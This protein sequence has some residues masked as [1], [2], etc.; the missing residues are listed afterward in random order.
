M[1]TP[2]G[3]TIGL[4]KTDAPLQAGIEAQIAI[5]TAAAAGAV[6]EPEDDWDPSSTETA[7][8]ARPGFDQRW[9]RT[10]IMAVDDIDNLAKKRN[11]R[12]SPRR[13]DTVDP[14]YFTPTILHSSL[15]DVICKGDSILMERPK[16]FGDKQRAWN[17]ERTTLQTG[18]VER[19][20][21]EQPRSH[22]G[23]GRPE[24]SE[25]NRTV[26]TGRTPKIADD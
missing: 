24:V 5:N 7:P 14:T 23:V 6:A 1:A 4:T 12:W 25:F 16:K 21:N 3:L 9:V 20:L 13:K 10:S 17:R 18:A 19:Y 22:H 2:A 15:G 8:P 11:Q 26:T